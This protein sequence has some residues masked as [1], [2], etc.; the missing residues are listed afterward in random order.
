[1]QEDVFQMYLEE[2]K[3]IESCDAAENETLLRQF[4]EGNRAVKDRLVEGNLKLVLE[5]VR[6]YLGRGVPGGDLVQ[7]ANMALLLAVG[8]YEEGIFEDY[9]RDK[10]KDA[11]QAAVEDQSREQEA[12]EKVLGQVNRLKD[13]SQEMAKELGREA[14]VEELADRMRLTGDEVREIMKLTLDAMSVVGN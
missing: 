8:E 12:A 6:D 3:E 7:E 4:R 5:I 2:I 13:V 14:S 10:V 9:V 1:M 11:L